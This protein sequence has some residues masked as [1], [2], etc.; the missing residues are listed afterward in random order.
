MSSTVAL[1][2]LRRALA[3]AAL[4]LSCLTARAETAP[5]MDAPLVPLGATWRYLVG[6][7]APPGD[8]HAPGFD[9]APWKSGPASIGYGDGDDATDIA[10][11]RAGAVT[12]YLRTAFDVRAEPDR[13]L[14]TLRFR[15]RY[16]DGFVAYLNG[17]EIARRGLPAGPPGWQSTAQDHE[18]KAVEDIAIPG[19]GGLLRGGR[20]VLAV[21]VHDSSAHST[22]L[23]FDAELAV[24]GPSKGARVATTPTGL[25]GSDDAGVEETA[26][27]VAVA[28]T[29]KHA[30]WSTTLATYDTSNWFQ[31]RAGSP[32]ENVRAQLLRQQVVLQSMG[33]RRT[34]LTLR[35][36]GQRVGRLGEDLGWLARVQWQSTP[37]QL[38]RI[39]AGGLLGRPAFRLGTQLATVDTR[40]LGVTWSFRPKVDFWPSWWL[41]WTREDA[42]LDP[43]RSFDEL[44]AGGSVRFRPRAK[45]G[46]EIGLERT[47]LSAR[48]RNYDYAQ[49]R[50]F[51]RLRA[52]AGPV[53]LTLFGRYGA[54]A[55]AG[56]PPLSNAGR[57]DIRRV[58]RLVA[59]W[60][61]TPH[62]G[63][64]AQ[65]SAEDGS[66]SGADRAF[67]SRTLWLGLT[68][69]F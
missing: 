36:E 41:L 13:T 53:R 31:G 5:A 24:G 2:G 69:S 37:R 68:C 54:R 49:D 14:A 48:S 66:S 1:S 67:T 61:I 27:H 35:V 38:V 23:T 62:V 4:A 15:A 16:D 17:T 30:T 3:A 32:H 29:T 65:V 51:L 11:Q 64:T 60:D 39:D 33:R 12:V 8:W 10:D 19:A 59:D 20:N 22:D 55:Y 25:L 9:D 26:R 63:L 6:T 34:Q 28:A 46:P 44:V 43:L 45:V 50:A 40:D 52:T 56:P 42:T 21:E 18:A 57:H 7:S 58:A 47:W